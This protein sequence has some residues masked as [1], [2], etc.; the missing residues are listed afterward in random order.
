MTLNL[1]PLSSAL[2]QKA[3]EELNEN[4]NRI[5]EDLQ[6]FRE[7]I[8][9]QPHIR[10][11]MDDQFLIAFLRGSKYSLEK[12]KKKLDSYYTIRTNFPE[13]FESL[14]DEQRARAILRMC[15]GAH[16][17]IPLGEGG[18][19]LVLMRPG[20]YNPD[21][22]S[23]YE[24]MKLDLLFKDLIILEDDHVVVGGYVHLIDFAGFSTKHAL[25]F[26]PAK[27]KHL[28]Y[29][30]EEALPIRTRAQHLFNTGTAFETIF[31]M[32]KPLLPGKV[33]ERIMVHT[34]MESVYQ[35]V[36]LKY[37]PKEYGGENGSIE[38]I[39]AIGEDMLMR[40][41]EYLAEQKEYGTDEKLRPGNPINFD[42]IFGVEGSFRKLEVD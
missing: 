17:P 6:M 13:L 33:K 3:I 37:F 10:S 38:E 22:A 23:L 36:P 16:L 2:Q 42:A 1:R 18:P 31:G 34:S 8:L 40:Y 24:L 21:L 27:M 11:R 25:Q 5:A 41:R 7:W 29:Y 12:A 20:H 4:P 26:Q 28:I 35:Q 32:M 15:L 9:K 39:A 14:V 30:T 19:R